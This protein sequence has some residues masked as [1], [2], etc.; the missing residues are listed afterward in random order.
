MLKVKIVSIGKNKEVWLET[1]IQEYIKRLS[2]TMGIE[3]LWVKTDEQLVEQAKK[4]KMV[5]VLDVIGETMDSVMFAN[6]FQKKLE[7]GGGRLSFVIGGP[8][9]LPEA[10]KGHP[11]RLSFSPLTFTHQIVR[12]LLLE[13]LYRA[14]E[15]AKGSPYHK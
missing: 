3:C 10:L 9:G 4:E 11:N 14:V 1:G 2:P 13:Q 12:L 6:Y 5:V 8:E 15:I 7:E